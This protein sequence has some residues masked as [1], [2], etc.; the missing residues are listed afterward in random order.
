MRE[1]KALRGSLMVAGAA[2]AWGFNGT[3]AKFLF[4][5]GEVDPLLLTAVRAT[6]AFPILAF[7]ILLWERQL[8]AIRFRDLPLLILVGIGVALANFTYYYTISLTTVATA[9]LLQYMAPILVALFGAAFLKERLTPTVLAA[10]TLAILGSSLMVKAY[11]PATLRLNL[12]GL[13]SGLL[14]AFSFA[15]YTLL[16]KKAVERLDSRTLIT[17]AYAVAAL[18]WWTMVPPWT[19]IGQG[20]A[21]RLWLLFFVIAAFGTALPFAL[22]ARGLMDLPA[23][24]VSIVSTLEPVIAGVAAYLFLDEGLVFSQIVGGLLVISGVI[25][26]QKG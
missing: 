25:L 13:F 24:R 10:L 8:L 4:I 3:L 18:G 16:S 17:Y 12:P 20:Y 19:F 1:K 22:Y 14:S 7:T 9:I 6:L 21:P 26:I 23:T 11:D 15:S 2:A 5:S